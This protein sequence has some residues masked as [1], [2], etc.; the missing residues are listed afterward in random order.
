MKPLYSRWILR[1]PPSFSPFGSE[2]GGSGDDLNPV[3]VSGFGRPSRVGV[4]GSL[5]GLRHGISVSNIGYRIL[6]HFA[7]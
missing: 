3:L 6:R 2:E 1:E 5:T 4:D 7:F